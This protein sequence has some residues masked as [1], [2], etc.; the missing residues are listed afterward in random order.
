MSVYLEAV[1]GW[2]CPEWSQYIWFYYKIYGH[3]LDLTLSMMVGFCIS[4]C[5]SWELG[6]LA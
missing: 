3:F 6:W 2:T 1:L 5:N 4:I